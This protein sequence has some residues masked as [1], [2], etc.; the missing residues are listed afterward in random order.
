MIAPA[1]ALR[2]I[3][4]WTFEARA[5]RQDD[6]AD[7]ARP[8]QSPPCRLRSPSPV[9]LSIVIV[10]NS[11][12]AP[13]AMTLAAVVDS[14]VLVLRSSSCCSVC[15][16]CASPRSSCS[17]TRSCAELLLQLRRS[18]RAP[19]AARS[20]PATESHAPSSTEFDAALHLGKDAEDHRLEHRHAAL[21]RDL[22]RDQDDVA[23]DHREEEITGALAN[24]DDGHG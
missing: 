3:S 17:R 13:P 5:A 15:D 7:D 1:A 4:S 6:P 22:R 8:A 23:D 2:S 9:P 19:A 20:S 10:R 24:V 12:L 16:C 14:V 11:G 18:R 21:G